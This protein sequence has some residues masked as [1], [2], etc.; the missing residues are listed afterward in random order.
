MLNKILASNPLEDVIG[1]TI[2]PGPGFQNFG[3]DPVA[4]FSK[5]L[6]T[7]IR[8]FI[9]GIALAMLA[10]LLWGAMD[11]ILS[12][13]DK[14]KLTK[15]QNKIT[16]AIIGFILVFVVLAIFGVVTGDILGIMQR[17]EGGGWQLVLPQLGAPTN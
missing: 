4:G 14:D 17:T 12:G 3:S 1:P 15:A 10:F 5:L 11:W 9:F 13:G 2:A 7:G 16:N 8:L 6:G